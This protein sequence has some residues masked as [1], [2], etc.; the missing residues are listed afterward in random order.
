MKKGNSKQIKLH[1]DEVIEKGLNN[2]IRLNNFQLSDNEKYS[3]RNETLKIL[4]TLKNLELR[5]LVFKM[6]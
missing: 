1:V 5:D 6:N 3:T 2:N 4:K